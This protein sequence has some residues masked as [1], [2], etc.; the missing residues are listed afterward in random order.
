[1]LAEQVAEV[2][3]VRA[4]W[5]QRPAEWLLANHGV[6]GRWCLVHAT[7][8]APHETE[9]LAATGAVVGLC[10]ITES[11]LGDGIFDARRYLAKGGRFGIGSDSNIR[12]ALA[13]ELRTLEYS[14]GLRDRVPAAGATPDRSTGRVLFDGAV[15]GGAQA[16]ARDSGAIEPGRVADLVALDADALDLAGKAG[17]AVLDGYIFAGDD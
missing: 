6:D 10:P 16:L 3:E 4:A 13:E 2:D 1:H 7:Q 9:A 17:D 15:R 8:M 11:N 14:Q 12:I 5:G